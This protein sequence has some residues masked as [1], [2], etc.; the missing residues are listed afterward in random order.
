[1][2][3]HIAFNAS[4]LKTTDSDLPSSSTVP[5]E[6][7]RLI[8]Y[9]FYKESNK[10]YL[11]S[12][13]AYLT[14]CMSLADKRNAVCLPKSFVRM[15]AE[16][17]AIREKHQLSVALPVCSYVNAYG[18][19]MNLQPSACHYRHTFSAELDRVVSMLPP[20]PASPDQLKTQRLTLP[21]EGYVQFKVEFLIVYCLFKIEDKHL[22]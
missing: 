1:M 12:L 16:S 18:K 3:K 2:R 22:G 8:S 11:D 6:R 20:P 9:T 14:R 5:N 13:H 7:R 17:R 21:T 10:E 19:C 4:R 15:C